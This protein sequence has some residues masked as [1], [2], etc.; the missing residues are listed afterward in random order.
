M[1]KLLQQN[2]LHNFFSIKISKDV[3]STLKLFP[4]DILGIFEYSSFSLISQTY[5]II[6]L[7]LFSLVYIHCT[8][9]RQDVFYLNYQGISCVTTLCPSFLLKSFHTLLSLSCGSL[10]DLSKVSSLEKTDY[11]AHYLPVT[12]YLGMGPYEVSPNHVGISTGIVCW[13]PGCL[14]CHI[15]RT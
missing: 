1:L 3:F 13:S 6:V 7:K 9:Y 15:Q 5:K 4:A 8:Q 2:F 12:L 10:D 14:H 11:L